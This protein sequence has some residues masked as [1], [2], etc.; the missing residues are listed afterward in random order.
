MKRASQAE[1][2]KVARNVQAESATTVQQL[3]QKIA[4]LE[5]QNEKYLA[6]NSALRQAQIEMD[7][8][9][10]AEIIELKQLQLSAVKDDTAGVASQNDAQELQQQEEE[11]QML[12]N[13]IKVKDEEIMQLKRQ[14]GNNS[15]ISNG[16]GENSPSRRNNASPLRPSK[17][18][19]A[20]RHESGQNL[21][22]VNLNNS[23]L[24]D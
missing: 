16:A 6:E 24:E 14:L 22:Q 18:G 21:Q 17:H 4:F 5:S 1:N 9:H 19:S 10:T 2:Q 12:V 8:R 11:N 13:L 3:S 23:R 15:T 20:S 7:E